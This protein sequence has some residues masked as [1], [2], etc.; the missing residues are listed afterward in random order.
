MLSCSAD[1]NSPGTLSGLAIVISLVEKP[2]SSLTAALNNV[3][4]V[5]G[6]TAKTISDH[7]L[8]PIDVKFDM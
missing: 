2:R 3:Y 8:F 7:I 4:L 5:L 1:K 6:R